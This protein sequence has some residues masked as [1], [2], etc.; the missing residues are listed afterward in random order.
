MVS[1]VADNDFALVAVDVGGDVENGWIRFEPATDRMRRSRASLAKK[2]RQ[3][4]IE[5]LED[6]EI[7]EARNA[8]Q[9]GGEPFDFEFLWK[10]LGLERER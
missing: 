2:G 4:V 1:T 9:E 10:R 6:F 8:L 7:H 5:L 3:A